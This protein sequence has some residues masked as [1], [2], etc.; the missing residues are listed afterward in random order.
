MVVGPCVEVKAIKGNA[1][2]SDWNDSY[3]RSNFS[4]ESVLV[5]AEV[6]RCVPK[7]K[8]TWAADARFDVGSRWSRRVRCCTGHA[9]PRRVRIRFRAQNCRRRR[10]LHVPLSSSGRHIWRPVNRIGRDLPVAWQ[11]TRRLSSASQSRTSLRN[12]PIRRPRKR[13]FRGK[14]LNSVSAVSVHRWRRV[15]RAT[16]LEVRS[17]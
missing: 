7:S 13:C 17:S 2:R 4:V 15:S 14:R 8:E 6:R 5:H 3:V 1:L 16:S 12:Q 10:A 11:L 9:Q